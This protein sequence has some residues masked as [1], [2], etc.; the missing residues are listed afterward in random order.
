METFTTHL[1]ELLHHQGFLRYFRN[2]SWIFLENIS[3]ITFGLLVGIL[4]ARYLGPENF[5]ILNY[6]GAFVAI[7]TSIAGLG[8]DSIVVREL[9]NNPDKRDVYLGTAFW[10]KIAGALLT[11]SILAAAVQFTTNTPT[12]NLY[13]YILAFTL[14]LQSFEIINLYFQAKVLSKHSS[15]CRIIQLILSS[16]FKIYLIYIE[17]DILWFVLACVVDS[18]LLSALL[19]FAYSQQKIG[20]FFG[21]FSLNTAKKMLRNS[22]TLI[23][24]GIAIMIYMRIDQIMIK[25]MLGEKAVGLYSAAVKVSEAWYF[26]PVAI[27]SSLF[28]AILNAKK[29]NEALYHSRLKQLYSL[30]ICISAV[31][32]LPVTFLS[33]KI[34]TLLYGSQY[35]GAASSLMIHIWAGLFTALGVAGNQWMI[36]ENLQS[37]IAKNTLLGALIN[38]ILNLILIPKHGIFGAA[39]ATVISYICSGYICLAFHRKSM[40]NFRLLTESFN[41]FAA[42]RNF[43]NNPTFRNEN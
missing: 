11:L 36:S 25:E 17:A 28:P 20:M 39:V 33:S 42:F 27:T 38:V 13:I 15:I 30:M 22:W 4:V 5:G 16:A 19:I 6:V 24:S 8:L 32:A 40:K 29:T 1:R 37:L 7:F 10:L 31:I 3:R 14:F 34:I 43:Q 9:V 41:L 18:L 26:I 23:F 35:A 21:I 12:T 2:I